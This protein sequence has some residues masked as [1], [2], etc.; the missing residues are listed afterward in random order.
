[1]R[2]NLA[3][4]LREA[5]KKQIPACFP[6]A[7]IVDHLEIPTGWLLWE[8]NLGEGGFVAYLLLVISPK[9]DRFTF[10][11]AWN[12]IATLPAST[13]S[14]PAS[15][16]GAT[17]A[18]F[19]LSRLWQPHGFDHWWGL[20]QQAQHTS[21]PSIPES[22]LHV[23]HEQADRQLESALDKITE[24]AIPYLRQIGAQ[25]CKGTENTENNPV[26]FVL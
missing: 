7:R 17:Q 22:V 24:F 5:A 3:K 1:M 15:R 4:Q 20:G 10:E 11:V 12:S 8:L 2:I 16:V 13:K 25:L 26:R 9:E 23:E 6:N 19:R 18:R 21:S 14:G